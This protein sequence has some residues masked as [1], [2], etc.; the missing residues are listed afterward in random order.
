[1]K[2]RIY[3]RVSKE[4]QDERTQLDHIM[5]HLKQKEGEHVDYQVYKD[6]K[7]SRKPLD[8]RSGGIEL[9]RDLQRGDT[10]VAMRLDRLCRSFYETAILIK[11]MD[12]AGAEV[13]LTQQPGIHN[14]IMLGVYAGMAEEEVK[15][16]RQRI[17][18][19][20]ESKKAR[21]ERYG[22]KLPYGYALHET[23]LIP[24]KKGNETVMKRGILIP[25]HEEQH[26]LEIMKDLR[27][28]G[29]SY[30][31]IAKV[32]TELGHKNR[33]DKPFQKMSIYRILERTAVQ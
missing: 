4:Q 29:R 13:L 24:V 3:L 9:L 10:V 5:R 19:K 15:L 20:L 11:A 18:E 7:T 1:M 16:L 14:K 21:G 6:K 25:Y 31:E 30:G 2:Y 17:S 22:S 32:L 26:V 12:A 27:E 28:E 8:K 23:K 33:E